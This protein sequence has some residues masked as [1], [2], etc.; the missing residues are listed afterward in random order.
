[1]TGEEG[2]IRDG[3]KTGTRRKRGRQREAKRG[4]STVKEPQPVLGEKHPEERGGIKGQSRYYRTL[5][6]KNFGKSAFQGN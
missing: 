5:F 4:Q 1:M 3:R 2:G 6:S